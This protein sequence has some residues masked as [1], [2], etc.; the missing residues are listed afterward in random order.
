MS[1]FSND[2]DDVDG[3]WGETFCG[4]YD[5]KPRGKLPTGLND[6]TM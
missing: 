3:L 4:H 5:N 2:H 6:S 1:F